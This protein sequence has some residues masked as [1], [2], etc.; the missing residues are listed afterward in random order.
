M[1][2]SRFQSWHLDLQEPARALRFRRLPLPLS[3]TFLPGWGRIER[4]MPA[5]N[6]GWPDGIRCRKLRLLDRGQRKALFATVAED[7]GKLQRRQPH[8]W[9]QVRGGDRPQCRLSL[10]CARPD[11][12]TPEAV[13]KNRGSFAKRRNI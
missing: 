5:G 9:L 1:S 3:A 13:A 2:Q 4:T 8:A 12:F 7:H 10:L 11:G 6:D